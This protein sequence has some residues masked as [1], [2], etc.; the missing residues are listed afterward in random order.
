VRTSTITPV[1]DMLLPTSD[2]DGLGSFL[3][4]VQMPMP[5]ASLSSDL[6]FLFGEHRN[7]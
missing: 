3:L 7:L 2:V 4:L 6:H 1:V 5:I